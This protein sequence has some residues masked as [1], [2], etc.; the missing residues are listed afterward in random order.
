MF[1][2]IVKYIGFKGVINMFQFIKHKLRKALDEKF[3]LSAYLLVIVF[4][5]IVSL[6]YDLG[7]KIGL[8]IMML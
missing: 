6:V 3:V 4:L 1:L 7:K 8:F 5:F 2:Q